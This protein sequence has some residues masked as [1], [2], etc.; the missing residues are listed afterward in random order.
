MF[1]FKLNL[2]LNLK[3]KPIIANHKSSILI[4]ERRGEAM[5]LS[6]LLLFSLIL[7]LVHFYLS[8][9]VKIAMCMH[10]SILQWEASSHISNQEVQT[11]YMLALFLQLLSKRHPNFVGAKYQ[12]HA[13]NH[14]RENNLMNC[15]NCQ[16][17]DIENTSTRMSGYFDLR[18]NHTWNDWTEDFRVE[19]F[20]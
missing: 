3:S 10:E 7:F 1:I 4:H 6:S 13:F 16:A 15:G 19:P 20:L 9:L 11:K 17:P 2:K 14:M 18:D 12:I 8:W 5:P